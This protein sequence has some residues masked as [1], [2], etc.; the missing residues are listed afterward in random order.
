M[1]TWKI[2]INGAA[3]VPM[4]SLGVTL[5]GAEF[6]SHGAGTVR[7]DLDAPFDAESPLSY[8]NNV[9]IIR[10]EDGVPSTVFSGT[11]RTIPRYGS[12]G[13]EGLQVQCEDVWTELQETVYQ[14]NWAAFMADATSGDYVVPGLELSKTIIGV[15]PDGAPRTTSAVITAVVNYATSVDLPIAMGSIPA[16]MQT[17][18]R[19][20]DGRTCA[21][22][23]LECLNQHPDWITWMDYST[24]VP[25]L[26]FT[27]RASAT[28][29]SFDVGGNDDV[30][31]FSITRR[32]DLI[33]RRVILN[34]ESAGGIE[35]EVGSARG[36]TRDIW[37]APIGV[38][39]E[40]PTRGPG[41][42][43]ATMTLPTVDGVKG[44]FTPAI[45]DTQKAR[46]QTREIPA[47]AASPTKKNK[48][49][50]L[51]YRHLKNVPDSSITIKSWARTLE[52]FGEDPPDGISGVLVSDPATADD[53]PNELVVGQIEEWMEEKTGRVRV[54]AEIEASG[55]ATDEHKEAISKPLPPVIVVATSASTG[56]KTRVVNYT[57]PAMTAASPATQAA[58]MMGLAR[59]YYE[60][61]S[62]VTFE[63]GITLAADEIPDTRLVGCVINLTGGLGEWMTM[64]ALVNSV[65]WDIQSGTATVSFGPPRWQSFV[66]FVAMMETLR[67]PAGI[68]AFGEDRT[69]ENIPGGGA[70]SEAELE[71]LQ[72]FTSPE[73]IFEQPKISAEF[74]HPFKLTTSKVGTIAKFKV[75]GDSSGIQD[76]TNGDAIASITG[77][78]D[79][80]SILSEKYVVIEA[81]VDANLAC[82]GWQVLAVS[83]ADAAEVSIAGTPPAQDK[84]R[85]LIGKV[86]WDAETLTATPWQALYSSVRIT[87]GILNGVPIKCFEAA[88]T[89]QSKI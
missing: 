10:D 57:P 83:S 51:K 23:I 49:L 9:R 72:G 67:S 20:L 80:H 58:G 64:A 30:V 18:V 3:A 47:D 32:D 77:L 79:L 43:I 54:E 48:W 39:D 35:M 71:N 82:S 52:D 89:V 21:E 84:L 24:P 69:G 17:V 29:R 7:L 59:A 78:N 81:A 87:T 63:G 11:C 1:T 6:R 28:S 2:S 70:G 85:L 46:I 13:A 26:N 34:F 41:V 60:A 88:P 15:T 42:L 73:T 66:D 40:L 5:A 62:Q 27:N 8:G 36:I 19:M 45:I 65:S 50:K 38:P 33:P 44:S 56:I 55:S 76:G 75:S 31:E 22:L 61:L 12:A 25:T 37:P 4:E 53:I 68:R 86:T 16:G 74:T 14:E